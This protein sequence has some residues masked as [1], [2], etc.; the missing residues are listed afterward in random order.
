MVE[1]QPETSQKR[2]CAS[3]LS[4]VSTPCPSISFM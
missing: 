4:N 3:S 1:D 2:H